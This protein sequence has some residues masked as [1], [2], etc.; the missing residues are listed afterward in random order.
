MTTALA[1]LLRGEDVVSIARSLIGAELISRAGGVETAVRIT[2]TEAYWAPEDRA[3]HAFGNRRTGRT[4]V[5]FGPPGHAYVYLCYG[6]HE[7]F[8]VV[9]GPAGQAHAV[10]IRAG[11]PSRGLESILERR[12]MEQPG[13]KLSSGP[14]VL[15]RALGID[16][17]HNGLDLCNSAGPLRLEMTGPPIAPAD[18]IASPRIGIN[19]AGEPWVSQPWR[20]LLRGSPYVSGPRQAL[21]KR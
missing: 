13:P 1:D 6:I 8:N 14:G 5:M 10:L 18:V 12:R 2:E 20:F 7:M 4:E 17:S 3:S 21:K 9:T 15:T 16:R 11:A 19:F